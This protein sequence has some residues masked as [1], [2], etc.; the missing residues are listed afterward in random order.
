MQKIYFQL[1]GNAVLRTKGHSACPLVQYNVSYASA[2]TIDIT[3]A[4]NHLHQF[5]L[6]IIFWS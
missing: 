5:N 1:T 4:N 3:I 2:V 6:E